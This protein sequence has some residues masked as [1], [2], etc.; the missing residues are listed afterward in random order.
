MA[1]ERVERRLAAILAAD[2]AGYSRLMGEDEAG[3]LARL[4]SLRRELI[5]P[6]IAA[7]KG[8]IVKTTGDGILVEFQ[9]VVEAVACAAEVQRAM[10]ER[11]AAIPPDHRIEFRVGINLGDVIAEA[12]GDLY[13]DGINVAARLQGLAAP[14]GIC[15]SR[16]VFEEVRDRLPLEHEYLGEQHVKNIARPVKVYRV[17]AGAAYTPAAAPPR[18]RRAEQEVRFCTAADGVRI[19]YATL[20][21]GP[22]LVKAANWL[23]HLEFDWQSPIWRHWI[24]AFAGGRQFVRY[25]ERGNGLSDWDVA[26]LSFEMFVRDLEAVV[27]ALGLERFALLA[28]SQGAGVSIAYAVRHP[29]RVSR[30]VIS[31]GFVVGWRKRAVPDQIA[32]R[33]ALLTLA[34]KGWGQDNPVFRQVFTS[35]LIPGATLKEMQWFNDLQRVSTSPENAVRLQYAFADID[36]TELLPRVTVPTLVL[37]SRD[38]AIIPFE[39]GRMLARGIPNARFVALESRNH[40]ILEHEPAWRRFVD[41]V[42]GFL[43]EGG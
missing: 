26:D 42:R 3:T 41:E 13:G 14:G 9:S 27:D 16:K 36:V 34:R 40:L 38:D 21:E 23:N 32:W 10:A 29:G 17:S 12:D 11:S 1:E 2:V 33:E 18:P 31:G 4:K 8:R 6:G 22:A 15:V 25:D 30:L 35:L 39:Q 20:G 7:H 24:E 5:D 37:H 19:A 43:D 28:V